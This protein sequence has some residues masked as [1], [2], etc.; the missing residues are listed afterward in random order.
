LG[1]EEPEEEGLVDHN[2]LAKSEGHL[3]VTVVEHASGGV[4]PKLVI[5]MVVVAEVVIFGRLLKLL[6]RGG[7]VFVPGK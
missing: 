3:D 6:D 1:Q 7:S 4:V 2:R 5:D